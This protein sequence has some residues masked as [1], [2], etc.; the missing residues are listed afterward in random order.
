MLKSV[1]E[2]VVALV[3]EQGA[4]HLDLMFSNP[5]DPESVKA[6][7]ASHRE[8]MQKWIDGRNADIQYQMVAT[9]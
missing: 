6:A 5:L 9:A 8:H 4:H 7:R 2:S 1:S 3:I